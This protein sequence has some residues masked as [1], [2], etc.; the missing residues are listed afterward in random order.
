VPE[1]GDGPLDHPLQ[2]CDGLPFRRLA[3]DAFQRRQPEAERDDG[4]DGIVVDV[5]CDPFPLLLLSL[6]KFL[7]EL[8]PR[9]VGPL[10]GLER[11][12]ELGLRPALEG[13]VLHAPLVVLGP[14]PFVADDSGGVPDPDQRAVVSSLLHLEAGGPRGLS[15]I[16]P[17]RSSLRIRVQSPGIDGQQ[18]PEVRIPEYLNEG[19][20]GVQDPAFWR[21]P[22]QADRHMVE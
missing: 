21:G 4:L 10:Q 6:D 22:E 7:Q 12:L 8:T 9:L 17:P 3:E 16:L 15:P 18:A 20:V 5:G 1:R 2:I 11:F 19:L 13:D 14:P